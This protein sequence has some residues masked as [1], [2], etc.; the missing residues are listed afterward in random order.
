[1]IDELRKKVLD[2]YKNNEVKIQRFEYIYQ[3]FQKKD[4]KQAQLYFEK[5]L[6]VAPNSSPTLENL[7]KS[8]LETGDYEKAEPLIDRIKTNN[9]LYDEGKQVIYHTAR[10][11]G[12]NNND[13]TKAQPE[14]YLFTVR[15]LKSWGVKFHRVILGKPSGDVYIDDK[16]MKDE[17]FYRN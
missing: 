1:M 3:I 11:M 9:K 15:Q 2:K 17:H 10:G 12:R 4:F 6:E 16:G 7:S 8:Y 5:T 14:F 13:A